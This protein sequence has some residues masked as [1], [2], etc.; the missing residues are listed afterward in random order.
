ME[1]DTRLGNPARL[2]HDR[3]TILCPEN[4]TISAYSDC[5][6]TIQYMLEKSGTEFAMREQ[7]YQVQQSC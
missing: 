6:N 7:E 2:M 1:A 3:S 5:T 4:E